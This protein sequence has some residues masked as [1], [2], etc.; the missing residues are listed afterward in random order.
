MWNVGSKKTTSAAKGAYLRKF[1][2]PPMLASG[3][4][5]SGSWLALT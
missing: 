4:L 5:P 3:L 1:P 2:L